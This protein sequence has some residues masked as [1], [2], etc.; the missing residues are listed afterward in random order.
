MSKDQTWYYLTPQKLLGKIIEFQEHNLGRL[1][2]CFRI[3]NK[4][5]NL[6]MGVSQASILP[7]E[8]II[9]WTPDD[10]GSQYWYFEIEGIGHNIHIINLRSGLYAG[11]REASINDE[12]DLIQWEKTNDVS[13]EWSFI[14]I[15]EDDRYF[16]IQ[17]NKSCKVLDIEDF[18]LK[19][20]KKIIQSKNEGKP[21]QLW[22][23]EIINLFGTSEGEGRL[24]PKPRTLAQDAL[25]I[26]QEKLD[27]L[28][29]QEALTANPTMKFELRKR[30]EE[31]QQKIKE[32][33]G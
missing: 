30:I 11:V 25:A 23:L 18:S 16:Q 1:F 22:F 2:Y 28:Q 5:S 26:W 29:V 15:A 17:N 9:Q 27:Y 33:G 32:L 4:A 14:R 3:R 7:G 10:Y 31:C 8:Q 21:S 20:G 19:R 6:Y 24:P 13:Q 12:Q